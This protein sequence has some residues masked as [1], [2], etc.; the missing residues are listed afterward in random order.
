M[1]YLVVLIFKIVTRLKVLKE[2]LTYFTLCT[3]SFQ[4]GLCQNAFSYTGISRRGRLSISGTLS[5]IT[6]FLFDI[7]AEKYETVVHFSFWEKHY[8]I[9]QLSYPSHKFQV[10]ST[11]A[12]NT[13]AGVNN[14]GRPP[15]KILSFGQYLTWHWVGMRGWVAC[16]D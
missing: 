4:L 13:K 6:S 2:L 9:L 8:S 12:E 15:R 5:S 14:L 3:W 10:F 7:I 1:R 11:I 16:P